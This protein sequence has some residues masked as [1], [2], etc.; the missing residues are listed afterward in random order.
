MYH[1]IGSLLPSKNNEKK[2]SQIFLYDQ[3]YDQINRRKEILD[4]LNANIPIELIIEIQNE[5]YKFN[6]FYKEFR[7][8][9]IEILNSEKEYQMN[10]SDDYQKL[11]IKKEEIKLYNAPAQNEIG[12]IIPDNE[13]IQ[14][15]RDII[16]QKRDLALIRISEKHPA[17]YPMSFV[18]LFPT[19]ELG[20][21]QDMK[22]ELYNKTNKNKDNFSKENILN[23]EIDS[24]YE[25][26]SIHLNENL[27]DQNEK[28]EEK[29]MKTI[30]LL[31]FANFY[32]MFRRDCFNLFFKGKK[33]IKL[34]YYFYNYKIKI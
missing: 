29:I 33:I 31:Q 28:N 13:K 19:G 24:D 2:F 20:W 16:I 14:Y 27:P 1:R 18:L 25:D 30:S 12:I 21:S 5:L 34:L 15:S 9:G 26:N 7:P 10:I 8:I 3:E 23:K 22:Y 32:L 4:G 11:K 6:Q 17:V